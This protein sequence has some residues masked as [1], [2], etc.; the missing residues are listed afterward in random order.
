MSQPKHRQ[1]IF[2]CVRLCFQ[3][4][5]LGLLLIECVYTAAPVIASSHVFAQTRLKAQTLN[6]T[7]LK[8][9]ARLSSQKRTTAQGHAVSPRSKG[10][11]N[12][13]Q[14]PL[15]SQESP[16][17]TRR[18]TGKIGNTTQ[19]LTITSSAP[20]GPNFH[21]GQTLALEFV[22]HNVSAS[23]T[24]TNQSGVGMSV[25]FP[26]GL[27]NMVVVT[28]N[29]ASNL[30]ATTSPTILSALYTGPPIGPGGV[31]PTITVSSMLTT[32]AVP[33]FTVFPRE[34]D[35]G[36][37]AVSTGILSVNVVPVPGTA[38]VTPTATGTVTPTPL[39]SPN[40]GITANVAG[41]PV[42]Q[43]GQTVTLHVT[44]SNT[45]TSE[46]LGMDEGVNVADVLPFGLENISALGGSD[47]SINTS[48]NTGPSLF[49]AIYI[50]PPVA[51]GGNFPLLTVTSTLTSAAVPSVRNATAV[52]DD[53]FTAANVAVIQLSVSTPATATPTPTPLP[54]SLPDVSMTQTSIGNTAFQIGTTVS[55]VLKVSSVP[56]SGPIGPSNPVKV[57]MVIPVGLNAITTTAPHWSL[58]ST[59]TTSPTLIVASYRG[60]YPVATGTQLP[61]ILVQGTV[62]STALP[63]LT[64]TALAQ[65]AGDSHPDN[66]LTTTTIQ[67]SPFGQTPVAPLS[68]T[69]TSTVVPTVTVSGVI[70]PL[71]TSLPDFSVTQ[72]SIGSGPFVAGQQ[73]GYGITVK[74][75]GT[76]G[77][78]SSL[79][80]LTEVIPV[81]MTN[82][83]VSAGASWH[84]TQSSTTSPLLITATYAGSYPVG[85]GVTL[86][87]LSV[88]GTIVHGIVSS[89][90]CTAVIGVADDRNP[91]NNMATTTVF[92][93]PSSSS[94][95]SRVEQ[96]MKIR[97]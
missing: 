31:F 46:A 49:T 72:A 43:V 63:R 83:T 23:T 66:N 82:V 16:S 7:E 64:S 47:W 90:T 77:L 8:S 34:L 56:T 92:V 54:P 19:N 96:R 70:A 28:S 51:V 10:Q 94:Q 73:L 59:S 11:R 38:T 2:T 37:A 29:W 87:P 88:I 95:I 81:G 48:S 13:S 27:S 30:S 42:Y 93:T 41:G 78:T 84:I 69:P 39:T 15:L 68:P 36:D 85:A 74:N 53:D 4:L 52:F 75:A 80:R 22:M 14:T 18:T 35:S 6:G 24:Y 86:A 44:V 58:M 9:H 25:F 17:I 33:V 61:P 89:M 26:L 50:G 20:G 40:V 60:Q 5:L 45:D 65:V 21:V 32:D 12:R 57:V 91:N 3:A 97:R 71:P 67:I 62:L 79:I 76:T 1:R 55:Y